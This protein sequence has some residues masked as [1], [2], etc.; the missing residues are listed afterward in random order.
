MNKKFVTIALI[1]LLFT[2]PAAAKLFDISEYTL[3]NGAR[4]LVIENHKAPI[5]KHMVWYRVGSVDEK[6]GKGGAAHLLEHLMFRGTKKVSGSEFNRMMQINGADGNAF[7]SRDYTAYHQSLDVSRLELAMALEA[8]R[9]RNLN[10]SDQDFAA[11]RDIVYQERKQVVENQPLSGFFEAVQRGLWQTHPYARSVS[12]TEEEILSLTKAD[13]TDIYRRYYVPNNAVIVISGDIEP[14]TAYRLAEK[15]Y[16]KLPI[17]HALA[18]KHFPK[19]HLGTRVALKMKLPRVELPRIVRYYAVDSYNTDPDNIYAAAVLADYLGG[20]DT[21][22]L[23]KELVI[24]KKLALSVAV[25]Y[26]YASRSYGTFSL[27]VVPAAGVSPEQLQ[28]TLDR[29]VN[30]AVA[31]LTDEKLA[32]VKN[33]MLAGLVYLR[34]NPNDAAYIVGSLYTIGMSCQDIENYADNIRAVNSAEVKQ[35]AKKIFGASAAVEGIVE[36]LG[37]EDKDE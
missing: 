17:G 24:K 35:A 2:F 36:P 11:E 14:E 27:M 5:V 29:V 10:F 6:T 19:V 31:S 4:L 18:E 37:G 25:S 23:Y 33:K 12:G 28:A 34:D 3:G 9:M 22:E 8:D 32:K 7:T 16:G 15:Y 30:E 20:S 21:S 1:C 13:I 26:D